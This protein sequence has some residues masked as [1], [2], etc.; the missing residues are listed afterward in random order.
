MNS[1]SLNFLPSLEIQNF[2]TNSMTN[3]HKEL[4]VKIIHL[5]DKIHP[6]KFS[7]PKYFPIF[8]NLKKISK[9]N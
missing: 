3:V 4:L 2:C 8:E 9:N 7:T 6:Q 5:I 1:C